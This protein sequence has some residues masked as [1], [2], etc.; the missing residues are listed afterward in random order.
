MELETLLRLTNAKQK[1]CDLKHKLNAISICARSLFWEL[2][3]R[4]DKNNCLFTKETEGD[5]EVNPL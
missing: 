2:S 3:G 4:K 1:R 5:E